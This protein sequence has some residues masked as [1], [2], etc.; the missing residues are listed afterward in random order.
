MDDKTAL[1]LLSGDFYAA[2]TPTAPVTSAAGAAKLEPPVLDSD[3][4]K[5]TLKIN[6]KAKAHT[7][8]P[9]TRRIKKF[10]FFFL[11]FILSQP[12]PGPVLE[13]LSDTLLPDA[14][15]TKTDKPKVKRGSV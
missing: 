3:P 12:M 4:L 13:S 6:S 10:L 9:M 2:P 7:S 14:V 11:V 1:D 5:V 8:Y 15:K